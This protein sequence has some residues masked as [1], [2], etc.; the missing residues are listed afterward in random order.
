LVRLPGEGQGE[1]VSFRDRTLTDERRQEGDMSETRDDEPGPANFPGPSGER[2]LPTRFDP[3]EVEARWAKRWVDEP[4]S[5]DPQSQKPAFTV[6]MPPPN[7]TG[8]LHLGH[9][10]DNTII[11]TLIRYKRMRG[12]EALFQPGSDHAGIST[13][14]QVEKA[15]RAEGS[16]RHELGRDAFLERVWAWKERYGGIIIDQLQ[17]LGVSAAWERQ[18]FTM[19]E[20]LSA[21]VRLQFVKLYQQQKVYRK[22]RIVNWDPV[23]QTVL[24]DLEVDREERQGEIFE[25]AYELADGGAVH[26]ATVRPETIFADVA[27]AVHPE[28]GRLSPLVGKRVRIP[29]TERWVEVIAD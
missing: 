27:V 24:S 12:F 26:I 8:A 1:V 9:A 10:Y 25:L 7:V 15:L 13:Q 29:L 5:A 23:S 4:F 19:D 20:G 28:D 2:E 22:E 14:V 18:R 6:V 3:A 17:R 16:S 21:A 11:D